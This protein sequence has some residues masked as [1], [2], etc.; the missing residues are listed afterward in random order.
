MSRR[1]ISSGRKIRRPRSSGS[2]GG[3][4]GIPRSRRAPPPASG[5]AYGRGTQ[6]VIATGGPA[7]PMLIHAP[8]SPSSARTEGRPRLA[9]A[10]RTRT[11]LINHGEAS[12]CPSRQARGGRIP[13]AFD[14]SGT[15]PSAA[16]DGMY[17]RPNAGVVYEMGSSCPVTVIRGIYPGVRRPDTSSPW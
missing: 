16:P 11:H 12:R 9:H 14:R 13:A 3:G 5:R 8:G 1:S 10:R 7:E 6:H 2:P 17:R 15:T 4:C